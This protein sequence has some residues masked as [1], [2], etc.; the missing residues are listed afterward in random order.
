MLGRTAADW[1]LAT[2]AQP[3]QVKEIFPRVLPTGIAHGTV[4][5]RHRGKSYELTTLRGEGAYSDGRRPDS[6]HFV[7]DIDEDLSRRDFTINAM[8][9][10]PLAELLTD[11]FDGQGDLGRGVIRAV[12]E[13]ERRFSEDG[14]RVLR[15]AR[16]CAT[17]EFEL[18]AAT[19]AAIGRTLDTFRK[20]SAE[21]VRDEWMKALRA[22]RPSLAFVI[23]KRTGILEATFAELSALSEPT[24][25]RS[26]N[27]LDDAP[28]EE[29][30]LRLAALIWPLAHERARVD[31]WL[32]DYR[33]SNQERERILR[34]L[35]FAEPDRVTPPSPLELRR[36][37]HAVGRTHLREVCQLSV[38][39]AQAHHGPG[40][41]AEETARRTLA[42]CETLLAADVALSQKELRVSGKELMD[43]LQLAPGPRIGELLQKLLADVLEDPTLNQPAPLIERARRALTELSP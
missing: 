7:T 23:M 15:A 32:S 37:G 21:R 40:S 1:D 4:T 41:L 30:I 29:P 18:E 13:A 5:V 43:A 24:F 16:F 38:L 17:L 39:L 3:R 42:E 6:V 10:D 22:R 28:A 34:C 26:L 11:P 14:L 19:E 31:A 2:D 25:E 9:F 33:F 35:R 8:A 27:A 36:R 12:G 20:V